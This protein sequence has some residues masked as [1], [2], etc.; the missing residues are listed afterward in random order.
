MD[1]KKAIDMRYINIKK[2]ETLNIVVCNNLIKVFSKTNKKT[3]SCSKIE[4]FLNIEVFY[5]LN[6]AF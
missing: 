1:I 2:Y 3:L 4:N 5:F 6:L